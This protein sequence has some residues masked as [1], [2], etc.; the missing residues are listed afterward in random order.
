MPKSLLAGLALIACI[1]AS[2]GNA[3]MLSAPSADP[4]G[5]GMPTL[6]LPQEVT[7]P[8]MS[9]LG[10]GD[11]GGAAAPVQ[12]TAPEAPYSVEGEEPLEPDS[13]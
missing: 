2:A 9:G 7:S 12:D 3:Q 11:N 5:A 4:A 13:N 1:W 10:G 8:L 6:I